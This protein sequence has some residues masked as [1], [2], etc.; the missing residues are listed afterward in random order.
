[1]QSNNIC[2][3]DRAGLLSNVSS[4]LPTTGADHYGELD[5]C[6][7]ADREVDRL[8]PDEVAVSERLGA[9]LRVNPSGDTRDSRGS[10]MRRVVR[11]AGD[12][13]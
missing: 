9:R 10:F 5:V 1:M 3:K 7:E 4:H 8:A 13:A 2:A 11:M 6:E 12:G